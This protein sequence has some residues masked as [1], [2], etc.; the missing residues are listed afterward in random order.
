MFHGAKLPVIVMVLKKK[1]NGN[2]DN[3][4]FIDASKYFTPEKAANVITDE[5]IDRI[6]DAYVN[7]SEIEG[8]SHVA[9]MDEIERNGF[10]CNIPRYVNNLEKEADV[11]LAE[12]FSLI[13]GLETK[14]AT[15][16]DQLKE[17][18]EGLGLEV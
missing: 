18:F 12:Q 1:R 5:D 7:R 17:Y 15:I 8:F 4:L 11:D 16:D 9:Y 6:M 3:I 13:K 2:S 14:A 10:N